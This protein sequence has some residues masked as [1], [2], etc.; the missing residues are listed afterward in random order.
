MSLADAFYSYDV[1]SF[2]SLYS[3]GLKL[4]S[5]KKDKSCFVFLIQIQYGQMLR[6]NLFQRFW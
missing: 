1:M 6:V 3:D 5:K 2:K 4:F